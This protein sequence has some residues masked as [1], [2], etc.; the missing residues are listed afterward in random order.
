MEVKERTIGVLFGCF[1]RKIDGDSWFTWLFIHLPGPFIS[2]KRTPMER[3]VPNICVEA[4]R[5]VQF[6]Q[7]LPSLRVIIGRRVTGSGEKNE[8]QIGSP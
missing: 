6:A 1:A 5:M 7:S 3:T 4:T 2:P 8:R